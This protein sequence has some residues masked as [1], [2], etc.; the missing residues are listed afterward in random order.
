M[1][2]TRRCNYLSSCDKFNDG[3]IHTINLDQ[4]V[5]ATAAMSAWQGSRGDV[6]HFD[7]TL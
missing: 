4:P 2:A 6:T 5:T 1:H 3:R 7:L